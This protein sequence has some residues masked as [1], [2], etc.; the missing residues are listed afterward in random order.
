[1]TL[2]FLGFDETPEGCLAH[3]PYECFETDDEYDARVALEDHVNQLGKKKVME[4]LK[5]I[6]ERSK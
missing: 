6:K 5:R 4:I 3:V 1:M 2:F